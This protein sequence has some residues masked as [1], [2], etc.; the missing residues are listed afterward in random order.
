MA[1]LDLRTPEAR[2]EFGIEDETVSEPSQ[3]GRIVGEYLD[4]DVV[5]TRIINAVKAS[6]KPMTR[7]Q[8]CRAIRKAKSPHSIRLIMS[9]VQSGDLVETESV[10]ASGKIEYL[11]TWGG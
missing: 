3:H 6:H 11:Y 7:L 2:R 8:I 9:L 10:K 5:L 4:R 1:T